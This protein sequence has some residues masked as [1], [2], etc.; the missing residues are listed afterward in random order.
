M[1]IFLLGIVSGT[2]SAAGNIVLNFPASW[3]LA[4]NDV[5]YVMV[6]SSSTAN[7]NVTATGVGTWIELAD[8]YGNDT[9]DVNMGVYRQVMGATPDSSVTLDGTSG[10]ANHAAIAVALR[11]V[12]T[13]AP[14]DAAS[15]TS[16]TIDTGTPDNPAI[17]TVTN[18]AWVL[19]FAASSEADIATAAPAGYQDLRA[20]ALTNIAAVFSRKKVDTAGVENPG[21]Y[22][23]IVGTNADSFCAVTVAVR[24]AAG[25]PTN[26]P[27]K[28][29]ASRMRR[30]A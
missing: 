20:E 21:A 9:T 28:M 25:G 23:S 16:Q 29:D 19:A 2:A 18:H 7:Q 5:V 15:T 13:G 24:P 8:L 22:S 3:G 6:A 10:S 12:D 27:E 17:T 30:A 1:A 26:I 4:Q 14:E 11:G